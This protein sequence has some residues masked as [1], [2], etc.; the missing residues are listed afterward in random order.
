MPSRNRNA[1][2]SSGVRTN[3]IAAASNPHVNM[4]R[5]SHRLAPKRNSIR[6]DGTSHSA[7]PIKKSPAP[8][9]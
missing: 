9:P 2:N 6:F 4:M 8:N 1:L 5:A 7:Y 3:S